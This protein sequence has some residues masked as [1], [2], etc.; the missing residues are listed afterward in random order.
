ML[1]PAIHF[2]K[3]TCEEAMRFYEKIFGAKILNIYYDNDAPP[4]SGYAATG[5]VMHGEMEIYGT[6]VNMCDGD[7]AIPGNMHVFNLFF[8]TIDETVKIFNLLKEGGKVE[9]EPAP[10]FWSPMYGSITDRYGIKWQ[11]MA[12]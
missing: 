12:N 11:I 8:D 3:G 10:V 7:N 1:V 5:N 9:T 4:D 6:S 2:S